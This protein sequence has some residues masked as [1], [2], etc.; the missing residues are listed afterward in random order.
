MVVGMNVK[1]DVTV[2]MMDAGMHV[3]VNAVPDVLETV[4]GKDAIPV[5]VMRATMRLANRLIVG[6]NVLANVLEDVM[7]PVV[8]IHVHL[9]VLVPPMQE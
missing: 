9:V 8:L 7:V 4:V 1:I 2:V 3:P 5:V 6:V